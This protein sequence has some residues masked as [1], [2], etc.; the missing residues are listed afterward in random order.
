MAAS[1]LERKH[2]YQMVALRADSATL[3]RHALCRVASLPDIVSAG[4][5]FASEQISIPAI[6][7]NDLL[8]QHLI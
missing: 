2:R 1:I 3:L 8:R 5:F 7:K 4:P 6:K